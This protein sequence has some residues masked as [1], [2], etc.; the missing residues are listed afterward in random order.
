MRCLKQPRGG[1]GVTVSD[2]I[3]SAALIFILGSASPVWANPNGISG[4]VKDE[5]GQPL[6]NVDL[7]LLTT[8]GHMV[9]HTTTDPQG[10]FT[11]T[12]AQAGTYTLSV[13]KAGFEPTTRVIVYPPTDHKPLSVVIAPEELKPVIVKAGH[14][15]GPG[16]SSTGASDYAVTTEDISNLPLGDNTKIT[17]V[18]AQMP[19]VAIDQNQQIHIRN[20]EGP[21]F[22]YQING[23]LVPLDINTNPPFISM[24]NPTFIKQLDLLDGI[25]PSRYSYATGGVVAI[26]TKDGCSEPDG[27]FSLLAGQRN[28][29]Q[30][31]IQYSGCNGKLSYFVSGLVSQS[32]TAFSSATPGANPVHDWTDQGEGF[33]FFSYEIDATTKVSL[34]AST[35]ASNNQLPNV[36]G[37]TPQFNLAGVDNYPSQGINSY[38]NFR[39]SLVMLALNSSPSEDLTY[40]LAYSVHHI[41]QEF[42]P[43]NTG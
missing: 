30:P 8:N 36:P 13:E 4:S 16:V 37:L 3:V 2:F 28:T 43:D 35:A 21:Q 17:D 25:L 31:S 42:K 20:T 11:I 19:G 39:D 29:I 24:I 33:G 41:S 27:S 26:Q 23:F 5:S 15:G 6:A 18:L 22:Q 12:P 10:Q 40:Q 7:E 9:A 34:L 1:S 14:S 32:N 38:L